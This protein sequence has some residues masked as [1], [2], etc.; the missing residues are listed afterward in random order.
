MNII[1]Y[2]DTSFKSENQVEKIRSALNKGRFLSIPIK[3]SEEIEHLKFS[4]NICASILDEI[5][6]HVRPGISKK[7]LNE[8]IKDLIQKKYKAEIDRLNPDA[9]TNVGDKISACFGHNN[10]IANAVP[11]ES[12]LQNGDIFG[13]D[14]SI[15]K[16]GWCGDTR[17]S[18]IVGDEPSPSTL[19]LFTTSQQAMWLAIGMIKNGVAIENIAN[20]V[21]NFARHRGCTMLKLPITAGHSLGQYH[22]DGWLIPLYNSPL[23]KDRIL[24]TGMVITIETFMSAGSG[25]AGIL[26]NSLGTLATI[27]DAYACYWEHAVAVTDSGCEILDLRAGEHPNWIIR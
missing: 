14:I 16:N 26:N 6:S 12:P 24:K 15:R 18:W 9:E 1:K 3:T 25:D 19:N 8:M 21:E 17:K 4:G 7:I 27:D 10:I 5:S 20:A 2:S 22:M 13:I 11:D 23:N